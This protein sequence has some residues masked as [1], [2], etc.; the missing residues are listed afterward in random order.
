MRDR[1]GN[2]DPIFGQHQLGEI[3]AAMGDMID[4][5]RVSKPAAEIRLRGS[6]QQS[7]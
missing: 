1:I 4:A 2:Q 5:G 6:D 7:D 3:P